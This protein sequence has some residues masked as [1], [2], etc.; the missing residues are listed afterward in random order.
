MIL[1]ALGANLPSRFGSPEK[2]LQAAL[3]A[4]DK[5]NI[6]V[7]AVSRIW[8]TE[9]VPASDQPWY[10]NAAARVKTD[11][12]PYELL[13]TLQKIEKDFGRRRSV[14]N[15]PRLLDLDLIAYNN[16]II[17]KPALIIPHPRAH[18]RAFVLYPVKEVAPDWE[19]PGMGMHVDDLIA[20]LPEDQAVSV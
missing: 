4:L 7:Q 14:R 13:E 19:H 16:V 8:L 12:S 9:P 18:R 1:I 15:A 20:A 5:N 3:S 6:T 2:T 10:R 11:L 17:N